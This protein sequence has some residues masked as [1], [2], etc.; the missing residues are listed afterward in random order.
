MDT[1]L[2]LVEGCPGTGKSSTAQYLARQIQSAGRSCR[3]Y[4]EEEQPHP[5]ASKRGIANARGF[6]EYGKGTLIRWRDFVARTRRTKQIAIIES[7]FLQ[8]TV[9]P[10]VRAQVKAARI[11]KV[12]HRM[13]EFC[14]RLQPVIIYL[15]QPDC[16]ATMRRLLDERGPDVSENYIRDMTNSAYAK[17]LGL[18]GFEGLV[19]GWV[20]TRSAME[21]LLA[22]IE[23]PTLNI[24]SSAGR[25]TTHYEQI[26][27]FLSLSLEPPPALS[28]Q[29]LAAYVGA[30]TYR[31]DV[32]P[33][34]TAGGTR[35]GRLNVS[36]RV[37]GLPRTGPQH[38]QKDVEFTIELE[39]G[40]LVMR[41]YGWL[42]PTNHLI[43]L[44]RDVFDIRSWPFQMHFERDRSGAVVG[45]TRKSETT[46]WQITGQRYLRPEEE[47]GS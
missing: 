39:K 25:W 6:K 16:A 10:L 45:A 7:H 27:D 21:Q 40:G 47:S 38:H 17:K 46:R 2:I 24:D 8:N 34:R 20:D 31:Q 9:G 14:A 43:P 33:R 44:K 1:R 23:L 22:E 41:D 15:N 35:F 36:R 37:G 29:D 42:R 26:G 5:V 18:E 13:A 28:K 19:Q 32:A 3:W 4:H 12:V 11:G 30:Y